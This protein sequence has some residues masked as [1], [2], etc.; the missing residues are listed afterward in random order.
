MNV[1]DMKINCSLPRYS[2]KFQLEL[3]NGLE[4]KNLNKIDSCLVDLEKL[5]NSIV[6]KLNYIYK[7]I[8]VADTIIPLN[9]ESEKELI[10]NLDPINNSIMLLSGII[11]S[12]NEILFTSRFNDSIFK[13]FCYF[14]QINAYH[15]YFNKTNHLTLLDQIFYFYHCIM[16]VLKKSNRRKL[17][18]ESIDMYYSFLAV[19]THLLKLEEIR[20][21]ENREFED[22]NNDVYKNIYD[23]LNEEPFFKGISKKSSDMF[24][25]KP[26][27]KTVENE[28]DEE[29]K[30][31]EAKN[32]GLV[33]K[34]EEELKN[35]NVMSKLILPSKVNKNIFMEFEELMFQ[36]KLTRNEIRT[37]L[38]QRDFETQGRNLIDGYLIIDQMIKSQSEQNIKLLKNIG[39]N[40]HEFLF[41]DGK[42]NLALHSF[43]EK[44][45]EKI[46]RLY[47]DYDYIRNS[48]KNDVNNLES[49]YDELMVEYDEI[50]KIKSNIKDCLFLDEFNNE[51]KNANDELKDKYIDQNINLNDEGLSNFNIENIKNINLDENVEKTNNK[52]EL[53]K[54]SE[55]K[56]KSKDV[57]ST[58]DSNKNT[59]N[60]TNKGNP[61]EDEEENENNYQNLG[62]HFPIVTK[63]NLKLL[64]YFK[65]II[66]F[67]EKE[68]EDYINKHI[69][70]K[71]RNL[72]II[73]KG[74]Y[75]KAK[76]VS[77]STVLS[78]YFM[79]IILDSSLFRSYYLRNMRIDKN[80][81][82][83]SRENVSREILINIGKMVTKFKKAKKF[84][85]HTQCIKIPISN[86]KKK[87][88]QFLMSKKEEGSYK[89]LRVEIEDFFL[90]EFDDIPFD[91]ILEKSESGNDVNNKDNYLITKRNN[92]VYLNIRFF[93]VNAA[94]T[95]VLIEDLFGFLNKDKKV[96]RRIDA[97][98]IFN[99]YHEIHKDIHTKLA[100]EFEITSEIRINLTILINNPFFERIKVL[101]GICFEQINEDYVAIEEGFEREVLNNFYKKCPHYQAF[102][103]ICYWLNQRE[104]IVGKEFIYKH[105]NLNSTNKLQISSKENLSYDV[106]LLLFLYY[107]QKDGRIKKLNQYNLDE[108]DFH[109]YTFQQDYYYTKSHHHFNNSNTNNIESG[110]NLGMSGIT[111]VTT[112]VVGTHNTTFKRF[113]Y[114]DIPNTVYRKFN[115]SSEDLYMEVGEIF[116]D[117][118]YFLYDIF[119]IVDPLDT[120]SINK[121]YFL[122]PFSEYLTYETSESES[123]L[124]ILD[125]FAYDSVQFSLENVSN[126]FDFS[127]YLSKRVKFEEFKEKGEYAI[128]FTFNKH[129]IVKIL[130]ECKRT[131]HYCMKNDVIA[132]ERIFFP[133]KK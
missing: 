83:S 62:N 43:N 14:G 126:T 121:K 51:L 107:L 38:E 8:S 104:I 94:N 45:K 122:N 30:D 101:S 92:E 110:N 21:N 65:K 34:I 37:L 85:T 123:S 5:F 130:D 19:D 22:G 81:I 16:T 15:S 32:T 99:Q 112:R 114:Y 49:I 61:N 6:E 106:I 91:R 90:S 86:F 70:E 63:F 116:T 96:I 78:D 40:G 84:K 39:E 23:H 125:Y 97:S 2:Y 13:L 56:I 9:K 79:K 128:L 118:I 59:Y 41:K 132:L 93:F 60:K 87:I 3:I 36:Y 111:N 35:N 48:I 26:N 103:L 113:Y 27:K 102:W 74:K 33:S 117:F 72:K 47:K 31:N 75:I 98:K 82:Y 55:V 120:E 53:S 100:F 66:L 29:L 76:S 42:L 109:Y 11:F 4:H 105:Y 50:Y 129:L 18:K 12:K 69:D 7:S 1:K 71:E 44:E 64:Y 58:K 57:K 133:D 80:L 28:N 77:V 24:K 131:I 54:K 124:S 119:K 115:M 10:T 108:H 73:G 25:I 95:T 68:N 52:N 67:I 46:M 88:Y 127:N 17:S 20:I 89:S